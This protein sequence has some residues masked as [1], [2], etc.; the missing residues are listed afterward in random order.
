MVSDSL[1]D[2]E[3]SDFTSIGDDEAVRR[4]DRDEESFFEPPADA[5]KRLTALAFCERC[6]CRL[7]QYRNPEDKLCCA[8]S[9]AINPLF[10]K[11]A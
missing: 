7:S 8:C 1:G 3:E 9:R 10:D 2:L 4:D 11:S 6:G 5:P